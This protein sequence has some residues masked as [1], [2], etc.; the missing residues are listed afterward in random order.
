MLPVRHPERRDRRDAERDAADEVTAAIFHSSPRAAAD[1]DL[2]SPRRKRDSPR[3]GSRS[4]RAR[5]ASR[6]GGC[7]SSVSRPACSA[8][9]VF[10][11]KKSVPTNW[12]TLLHQSIRCGSKASSRSLRCPS[13]PAVGVDGLD[14]LEGGGR[15]EE[16][17]AD[18]EHH[19]VDARSDELLEAG[20]RGDEEARRADREQDP[21]P[22]R[23]PVRRPPDALAASGSR[24]LD[25]VCAGRATT[26][27]PACHRRAQATCVVNGPTSGA[28]PP[29]S[30]RA[31]RIRARVSGGTRPRRVVVRRARLL[32]QARE[33]TLEVA[34]QQVGH[35]VREAAPDDDPQR[36]EVGPVGRERVG[37][38]LPAAFAQRARDVEDGEVV[39]VVA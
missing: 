16:D 28:R 9:K 5:R 11:L 7:M 26:R 31:A 32:L 17:R 8:W 30:R 34:D 10:T 20:K 35:V 36:R 22:P 33:L 38:D 15:G 23:R 18:E 29:S 37:R 13:R 14:V 39:D 6:R 21:D 4:S 24:E 27:R 1:E 2:R 3:R 25:G 19:A 12:T